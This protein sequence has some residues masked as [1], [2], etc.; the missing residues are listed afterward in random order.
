MPRRWSIRMTAVILAVS[1][2]TYGPPEEHVAVQNVV[3]APD[4]SRLAAIVK[5]ERYR[6]PTGLTAF[7]DGGVPLELELRADLYIASPDSGQVLARAELPAEPGQRVSFA[8]WALGWA[9]ET[10]FVK[11]T[12]CPGRRG[13]SCDPA[14]KTMAYFAWTSEHGFVRVPGPPPCWQSASSAPGARFL[15]ASPEADGVS[16]STHPD[17]PRRPFLRLRG[18]VLTIVR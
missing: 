6:P 16:I 1:G 5:Y 15:A 18:T 7:P 11:A 14:E 3:V 10:V 9:G 2:C 13:D 12:G 17:V 8:P 4:G